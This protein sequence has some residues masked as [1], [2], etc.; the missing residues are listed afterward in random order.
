MPCTYILKINGISTGIELSNMIAAHVKIQSKTLGHKWSQVQCDMVVKGA[1]VIK[2]TS[3]STN[4]LLIHGS[5]P[6]YFILQWFVI[7]SSHSCAV[8]GHLES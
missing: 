6:S 7:L 4:A 3:V 2:P 1:S 5:Q 8:S